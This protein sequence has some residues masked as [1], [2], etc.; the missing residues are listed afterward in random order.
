MQK[1][2]KPYLVNILNAINECRLSIADVS[3]DQFLTS[4]EHW[5]SR[6]LVERTIEIISEASRRVSIERKSQASH[7]PWQRVADIGNRLR[8]EYD[9]LD[10]EILYKVATEN[11]DD[12]ERQCLEWLHEIEQKEQQ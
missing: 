2:D 7:I 9:R 6:R 8:H 11:L 10:E 3:R 12:L 1:S 5:Q 4:L